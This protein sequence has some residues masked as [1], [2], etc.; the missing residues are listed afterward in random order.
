MQSATLVRSQGLIAKQTVRGT[1]LTAADS[2]NSFAID[3]IG[4]ADYKEADSI[5]DVFSLLSIG[6]AD[7]VRVDNRHSEQH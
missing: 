5:S 2:I 4:E 7:Y 3:V 1:K 6:F